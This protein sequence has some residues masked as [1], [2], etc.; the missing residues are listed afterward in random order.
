[1]N[2]PVDP[3]K[4]TKVD[5]LKGEEALLLDHNYDGIHELD[6]VLPSW[7]VGIFVATILFSAWYVG[8]YMSGHGPNPQ[9][10]LAASLAEIEAMK[11]VAAPPSEGDEAA[12]LAALKDPEKQKHGLEVY[13]GKCVACHGDK[14]Q[15]LIGPNLTD[16]YWIH[17]VGTAKDIAKVIADGVAEKGMP[18]WGPILTPDELRDTVAFIRSL[19][20]SNPAGAKPA[21]GEHHELKE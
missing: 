4:Q 14:G 5:V 15:G 13:M 19:H 16:D 7:W 6:H 2:K 12:L 18:P 11:P 10:E 20:A 1:M 8:Y 17:G 3:N 9:Q 21:Q